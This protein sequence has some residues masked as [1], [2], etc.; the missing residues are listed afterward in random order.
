MHMQLFSTFDYNI[1]LEMAIATLEKK[2]IQKEQIY[3]IPLDN[4][5]ENRRMFDSIHQSDGISLIDI[6]VALGTAFSVM[7]VAVGFKLAWGPIW[8]GIISACVGF[9]IGFAIRLFI[10]LFLKRRKRVLKGKQSEVI[11]IVDCEEVQGEL[12][13]NIL[14]E[15][16]AFGVARVKQEAAT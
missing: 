12:V 9:A 3:A 16:F 11:L 14:W 2:G 4:R 15:H 10:E 8:W 5:T 13:E 6:G 1:Y 7:G